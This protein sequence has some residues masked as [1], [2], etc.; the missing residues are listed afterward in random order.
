MAADHDELAALLQYSDDEL[1]DAIADSLFGEELGALPGPSRRD[2]AERWLER[3]LADRRDALCN[4]AAVVAVLNED[5]FDD[6]ADAA[7]IADALSSAANAPKGLTLS[8]AA[9][10]IARRGVRAICLRP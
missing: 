1:L 4:H 2:R 9:L 7:A 6:L 10:L 5:R 3:F 8:A